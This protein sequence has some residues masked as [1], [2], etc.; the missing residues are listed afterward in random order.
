M[1]IDQKCLVLTLVLTIVRYSIIL[2]CSSIAMGLRGYRTTLEDS[3]NSRD[4]DTKD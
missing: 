2:N 1:A 4:M 3:V